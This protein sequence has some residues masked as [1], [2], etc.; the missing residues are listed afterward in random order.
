MPPMK[1]ETVQGR[2]RAHFGQPV[3]L[4]QRC[5]QIRQYLKRQHRLPL[6]G[7]I[8]RIL[9]CLNEHRRNPDRRGRASTRRR[10]QRGLGYGITAGQE[11]R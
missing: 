8:V 10:W 9:V 3:E 6:A 4:D 2:Q 5:K 11:Q 1:L 7:G